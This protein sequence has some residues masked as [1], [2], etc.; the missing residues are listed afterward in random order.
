[1]QLN[2]KIHSHGGKRSHA[3]R[4]K[5]HSRGLRHRTREKINHRSLLHINFRYRIH[6]RN[7]ETLKL[8]K[9]AI[10]NGRMHGLNILHFSF[11]SNHVHLIVEARD[12]QTL[13]KGM[14]SLTI[15]FAKGINRGSIQLQRYHL[16]VLKTIRECKNAI[17]YVL[18]NQQK[19]EKGTYSSIDEY[20]S[21]L[22][23]KGGLE[24]V[25]KFAE[26]NRMILTI[27]KSTWVPDTPTTYLARRALKE[28][29]L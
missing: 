29:L 22:C 8:L 28:L 4:K 7:K 25:R 18:F 20:S 2:L 9:K 13:T 26:K 5:I 1:M 11:Q 27:G 21:L 10:S 16:H 6:L 23:F 12:N 3:G 24:L 15:T 17:H 14:R 19:H